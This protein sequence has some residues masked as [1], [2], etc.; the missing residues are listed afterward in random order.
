MQLQGLPSCLPQQRPLQAVQRRSTEQ[1]LAAV[2]LRRKLSN[3]SSS[4]NAQSLLSG[5]GKGIV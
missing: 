1:P 2:P 4:G 3:H 5:N